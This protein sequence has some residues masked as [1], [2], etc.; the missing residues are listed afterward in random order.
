MTD[1][2][3]HQWPKEWPVISPDAVRLQWSHSIH[4]ES[5][6]LSEWQAQ[7]YASILADEMGSS[8]MP[9]I[10]VISLPL[11]K[12][13]M[14]GSVTFC[15]EVEV[16]IGHATTGDFRSSMITH[17]ALGD[18]DE[19]PWGL[20]SRCA[21]TQDQPILTFDEPSFMA[22][23]PSQPQRRP[24]LTPSSTSTSPAASSTTSSTASEDWRQTVLIRLDGQMTPARLPWNDADQ[25]V[26]LILRAFDVPGQALYGAHHVRHRPQDLI[27]Q[28][29]ECL[30]IQ[31][32]LEP[33]P[34]TFMRL[35]LIDLEIYEP[36]EILPG[37]FRRFATWLPETLNRV[38]AFR[39]LGIEQLQ[40]EHPERSHLW[41]NNV[42]I[43]DGV[44]SPMYLQDGD[45]FR[46]LIGEH[47]D[48]CRQT[49]S[50][51]SSFQVNATDDDDIHSSLQTFWMSSTSTSLDDRTDADPLMYDTVCISRRHNATNGK[52][53]VMMSANEPY[54]FF[55]TA[56]PVN[57]VTGA[58][59][60]FRNPPRVE[61]DTW[62]HE[63]WDIL[64]EH[65]EVEM[66]EEGPVIYVASHYISH[67]YHPMN[68]Q[69]RPL[70][71]DVEHDSWLDD[72]KF[73]WEDYFDHNAPFALHLVAPNP[74]MR[75]TQSFV[76]TILIV[77]HSRQ[78]LTACVITAHDDEEPPSYVRQ[79][80][81]STR[82]LTTVEALIALS[83]H[84]HLC[85]P[86]DPAADDR[87]QLLHG[88]RELLQ[89]HEVRI[90]D[91][92]GHALRIPRARFLGQADP[93]HDGQPPP[94]AID[95]PPLEDDDEVQLLALS[96]TASPSSAQH[97]EST[98][99]WRSWVPCH[100]GLDLPPTTTERTF[101]HMPTAEQR[102]QAPQWNPQ[103]PDPFLNDLFGL[104]D[105]LAFAWEDEPRSGTVL[106]WFVDHQW[107][108]PHCLAPR[109]VRL[110]PAFR[111]W[112]V[113]LW[114]AWA[115]LVV[116][117]T[118]LEYH[119]VTPKPP[120]IERNIIAHV[121]LGYNNC[122]LL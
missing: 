107:E 97:L 61:R 21:W 122:F 8:S 41:Y 55:N 46:I 121:L 24:S 114:Q 116:L 48:D 52:Q 35:V 120:T 31:T 115:D 56:S 70:R 64:R 119:L 69:M 60:P 77:Q 67:D 87:C 42:E 73:M 58:D 88:R 81:H 74:P 30:L 89:A 39:L 76:A 25:I 117:G 6:Y 22:R 33:R 99:K 94:P 95:D 44:M 16:S 28:G 113:H 66:E 20:R 72:L 38:S 92:Q 63:L 105:L 86:L 13:S 19:K 1:G 50:T 109:A 27:Q 103:A 54:S 90:L 59:D 45:Y 18:F 17:D 112:R 68:P 118:E 104:W 57:D 23:R 85:S 26:P 29:L 11:R 80:A 10:D 98:P 47:I 108:V 101:Y 15:D 14:K 51:S 4:E 43:N 5:N 93:L 12:K 53:P 82:S 71:F 83:G 79:T 78:D 111:E 91:G 3:T 100:H 7:E 96:A 84:G 9:R 102:Q 40:R 62:C 34:S 75:P 2:Y 65:G 32:H 37:A 49:N 36:N 110:S 106:V